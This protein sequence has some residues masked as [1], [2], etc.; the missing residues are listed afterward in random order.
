MRC[1]TKEEHQ[2]KLAVAQ[3]RTIE[4]RGSFKVHNEYRSIES[5]RL[6]RVVCRC[7]FTARRRTYGTPTSVFSTKAR[8]TCHGLPVPASTWNL[9]S[10]YTFLH[11]YY[12]ELNCLYGSQ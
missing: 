12:V 6:P 8:S 3:H 9:S 7:T 4:I 5:A 1:K 11:T 2:I 10:Y